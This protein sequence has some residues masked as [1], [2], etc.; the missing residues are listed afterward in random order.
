MTQSCTQPSIDGKFTLLAIASDL[1]YV[2][3]HLLPLTT[4]CALHI[5]RYLGSSGLVSGLGGAGINTEGY[6]PDFFMQ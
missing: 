6:Y 5:C 3:L 4:L 1:T 2:V